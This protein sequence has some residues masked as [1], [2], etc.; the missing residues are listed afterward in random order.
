MEKNEQVCSIGS[1]ILK[2]TSA[3]QFLFSDLI[4]FLSATLLRAILMNHLAHSEASLLKLL[5]VTSM[6]SRTV[7]S[8]RF[9]VTKVRTTLF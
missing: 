1:M 9:R 8:K 7:M 5:R 6:K 3:E 4:A 2:M